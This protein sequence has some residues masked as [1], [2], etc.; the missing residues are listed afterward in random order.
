MPAPARQDACVTVV[1]RFLRELT[2]RTPAALRHRVVVVK[3]FIQCDHAA[4][5]ITIQLILPP[6]WRQVRE[7]NR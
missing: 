3:L 4:F 2:A 7:S 1:H 5:P 6:P